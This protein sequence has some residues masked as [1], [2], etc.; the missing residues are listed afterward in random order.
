MALQLSS[1]PSS[2]FDGQEHEKGMAELRVLSSNEEAQLL[3]AALD[4]KEALYKST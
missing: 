1:P 3:Q 4:L 2:P